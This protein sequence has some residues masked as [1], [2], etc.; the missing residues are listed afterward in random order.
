MCEYTLLRHTA[1]NVRKHCRSAQWVWLSNP[2]TLLWS[3]SK[4]QD[5]H[6]HCRGL[7]SFAS[8][9]AAMCSTSLSENEFGSYK[10]WNQRIGSREDQ[11]D[12]MCGLVW[13]VEPARSSSWCKLQL[14]DKKLARRIRFIF[15]FLRFS[16]THSLSV[17]HTHTQAELLPCCVF[18]WWY[19]LLTF[20]VFSEFSLGNLA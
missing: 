1:L 8:L 16:L 11:H 3:S 12:I 7:R 9:F 20:V 13:G 19:L 17:T 6:P 18:L 10:E 4:V 14:C 2:S 5:P 15:E